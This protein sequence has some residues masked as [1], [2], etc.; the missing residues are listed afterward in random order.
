MRITEA[1]DRWFM[2]LETEG[3]RPDTVSSY[4]WH[5]TPFLRWLEGVNV[6]DLDALTPFLIRRWLS[7][8]QKTHAPASLKTVFVSLRAFLRW[9]QREKLLTTDPLANVHAPKVDIPAKTALTPGQVR[10]LVAALQ[11]DTSP[12]GL[13]NMA[14]V[15]VM[16]DTGARASEVCALKLDDLQGDSLL[17]KRTKSGRPRVGFLGKRSSQALHRY[18]VQGRTRLHPKSGLL[19]VADNGQALTR[20]AIRCVLERLSERLGFHVNAHALRHTWA[21]AMARAG[22]DA[23]TLMALAGWTT[24]EMATRYIHLA[25][26][27][28]RESHTR[29]APLDGV[30]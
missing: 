10:A 6:T 11:R 15:T 13:R 8:Y 24:P 30:L 7:E 28:L 23:S 3:R 26:A 27:D 16:L 20:N 1:L 22:V 17:L 18:L 29:A 19:F 9:T 14:L 5:W 25:A 4:K 21:T 12:L 2:A